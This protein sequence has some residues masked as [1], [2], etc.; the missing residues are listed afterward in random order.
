M[1]KTASSI[2]T[3][4]VIVSSLSLLITACSARHTPAPVAILNSQP[5][6]SYS[7][8]D[9]DTYVVKK[10]DTL[11]AI[12]WYSGNDYRDLAQWNG[13]SPPYTISI[14]QTLKLRHFSVKKPS[15]N[16][17]VKSTPPT[18]KEN[19]T[20]S[21]AP[22]KKQAYGEKKRD[23]SQQVAADTSLATPSA[24]P[25]NVEHWVWPVKGVVIETFKADGAVNRG[26]D[27][28]API[29][30]SV[31]SAADGKVVYTGN[32][33]RGYGNLVIVKHS[34]TFLSAYAHNEK[35]VV[36]ERD[37]VKAGQTIATVGNSGAD[38]NKLHFEVRYRGKSLDPLRFL[39]E[40][41]NNNKNNRK[42]P[43]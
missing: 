23:V 8:F 35:I 21:V 9:A 30:T 34:E 13:I 38:T 6:P 4:G 3:W 17:S 2:I 37:W 29:G 25:T 41:N 28:Q 32:A 36:N 33:L 14:G 12:A 40:K 42:R 15:L 16:T 27:I 43:Y 10:G 5:A 39:P 19:L 7:E 31:V 11:F 24:F 26:I 1:R 18:S 20:K 22:P